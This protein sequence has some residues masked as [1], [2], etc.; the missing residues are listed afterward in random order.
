MSHDFFARADALF[1]SSD[2]PASERAN[3][4]LRVMVDHFDARTDHDAR[5]LPRIFSALRAI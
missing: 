1:V 5:E 3:L 2:V 4:R